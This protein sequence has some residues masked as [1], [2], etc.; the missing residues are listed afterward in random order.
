MQPAA[1]ATGAQPPRGVAVPSLEGVADVLRGE[2]LE[3]RPT[4]PI[5]G[6]V[7]W[8][9]DVWDH[10]IQDFD[11]TKHNYGD[12]A[13]HSERVDLNYALPELSRTDKQPDRGIGC[14]ATRWTI[15]RN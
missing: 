3:V 7:V 8:Q 4:Y 13:A 11:P 14:T 15:T 5:G 10:L 9:W 12:V 6:V 1:P 2:L